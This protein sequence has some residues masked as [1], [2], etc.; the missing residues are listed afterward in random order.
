MEQPNDFSDLLNL[1]KAA[2]FLDVSYVTI[3]RW[4]KQGKLK[5][6]RIGGT[7]F[8]ALGDLVKIKGERDNNA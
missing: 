2:R 1:T 3:Y 4:I 7:P 5:T 8:I 6:V